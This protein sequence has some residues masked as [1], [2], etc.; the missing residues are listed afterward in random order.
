MAT[1][2][3][4]IASKAKDA[5]MKVLA[6][7]PLP[8]A[9]APE[10]KRAASAETGRILAGQGVRFLGDGIPQLAQA[11]QEAGGAVVAAGQAEACVIE[12]A[13]DLDATGL[14]GLYDVVSDG[15]RGVAAGGRVLFVV[16]GSASPVVS[17]ALHALV[18]TLGREAGRKGTTVNAVLGA[19][20]TTLVPVCLF[21]ISPQAAYI[22]GQSVVAQSG[23]HE[24]A[25]P[26]TPVACV[27]GAAQGIGAAIAEAL[28]A[29]GFQVAVLDLP[30]QKMSAEA[31]CSRLGGPGR[32]RFVACD[33]ADSSSVNEALGSAAAMSADGKIA[34]L[35]NNAGITRDRTMA[36]MS[37]QEWDA[38]MKVNLLAVVNATRAAHSRLRQGGRVVSISST[39]GLSGNFG[40]ANYALAKGAILGWTRQMAAELESD[41]IGVSC[42]APGLITTA[43]TEAVPLLNREMAR[44]MIS[45]VQP[46]LPMDVGMAVAFL[47]SGGAWPLRGSMLRVDGGMYFGA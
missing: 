6:A 41:G 44:Q 20:V 8:I 40:Q 33:V 14:A 11:V 7:L 38:V 29:A 32:A 5:A 46:G 19:D 10:L 17:S 2:K 9:A 16:P 18:R 22:S 15:V 28:V 4:L 3:D 25:P 30:G 1:A 23:E 47:C 39:T 21:L 37:R 24:H 27:T 26:Q 34:A 12:V 13:P 42:V 35:V 43:M 45:L 36:K 31:L